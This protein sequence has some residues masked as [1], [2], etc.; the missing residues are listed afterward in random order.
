MQG[1]QVELPNERLSAQ[2]D[3]DSRLVL[4]PAD[5]GATQTENAGIIGESAQLNVAHTGDVRTARRA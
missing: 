3:A 1:Y 5:V 4:M 2:F